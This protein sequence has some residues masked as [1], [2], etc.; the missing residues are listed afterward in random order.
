MILQKLASIYNTL[1]F[2]SVTTAIGKMIY[3][4]TCES[5]VAL[6]GEIL[7]WTKTKWQKWEKTFPAKI[8]V[9]RSISLKQ[10]RVDSIDIHMFGDATLIGTTA[11]AYATVNQPSGNEQ[12]LLASKSRF[13][14]K[15]LTIPRLELIAAQMVANL[16][17]NI[18]ST[19]ASHKIKT[20]YRWSD[21]LVVF[22]WLQGHDNYKQFVQ[23]RIHQTISKGPIVWSYV[24]SN[25]NRAENVQQTS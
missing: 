7:E 8:E 13:S 10:E 18:K 5:K 1:G 6:D 24:N 9:P 15:G 12:G 11:V 20:I 22:Q 19:I 16:A 25:L 14:R 23:N 21:S 4:D 2:I 17:E 3:R